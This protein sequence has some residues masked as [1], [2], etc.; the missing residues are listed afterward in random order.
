M[1]TV[2]SNNEEEQEQFSTF[3]DRD[4]AI[5]TAAREAKVTLI[6]IVTSAL[7]SACE[8][9]H[10]ILPPS[11]NKERKNTTFSDRSLT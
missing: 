2:T 10:A 9:I 8:R 5:K 7:Y 4:I 1:Q 11:N 3:Q 6:S